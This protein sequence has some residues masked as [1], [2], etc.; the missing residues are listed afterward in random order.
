VYA[1][2]AARYEQSF[3]KIA[4]AV[5]LAG[6]QDPQA[7]VFKLVHDWLR[8]CK[9]RWLLV[10]DNAD[11]AQFLLDRP[12][13]TSTASEPLR[14]YIPHCE[15]GSV[16]VTTR[17]M[18]AALELVDSRDIVITVEPMN[19]LSAITLLEKKLKAPGDS[20]EIA[21]L[22]AVLEYMPLAIVQAAAYISYHLPRYSIAKYLDEYRKSER[23]RTC[24]LNFDKGKLR[25]D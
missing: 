5:K 11:D 2:N 14:E 15:R 4:D 19:K 10:L 20:T 25:R 13:T 23:K 9:H 1:S 17:N 6:R 18:E 8:E 12:L 22:V 3:R 7:N 21:K 16:L 24:L